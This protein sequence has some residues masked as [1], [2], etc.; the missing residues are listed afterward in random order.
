MRLTEEQ[1]LQLINKDK[2]RAPE[3]K[4]KPAQSFIRHLYLQDAVY[5][6]VDI[7]FA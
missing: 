7:P 4:K 3:I 5:V 6:G 2:P 1:Y